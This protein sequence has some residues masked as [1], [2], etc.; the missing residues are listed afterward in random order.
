MTPLMAIPQFEHRNVC[1][2][3]A[4]STTSLSVMETSLFEV[5][6]MLGSF[7]SGGFSPLFKQSA[8]QCN[9]DLARSRMRGRQ[10][11]FQTPSWCGPWPSE[12][13]RT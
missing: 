4:C 12:H 6:L 8:T 9:E 1:G 7:G 3:A 5:S 2:T 13:D 10:I 11:G